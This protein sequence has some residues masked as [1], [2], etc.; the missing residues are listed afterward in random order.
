M[1]WTAA[2]KQTFKTKLWHVIAGD[3]KIIESTMVIII[4]LK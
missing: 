4:S 2:G 3:S 1:A